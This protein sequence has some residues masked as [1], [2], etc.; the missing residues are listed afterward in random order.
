MFRLAVC[1]LILAAAAICGCGRYFA[2]DIN[3]ERHATEEE[4]EGR[5]MLAPTTLDL[6]RRDGYRPETGY[7][8]EIVFHENGTCDFRSIIPN[9]G[10]VATYHDLRGRWELRHD[11]KT[12]GGK[13]IKNEVSIEA[14]QY[15]LRLGVTEEDKTLCL[16]EFWG[17]P[18]SW[19]FLKYQKTDKR[20]SAPSP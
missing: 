11:A 12:S 16:W 13:T 18:D 14:G 9:I 5:W 17:D 10:G 3:L 7:L 19:E 1:S 2:P 20:H 4:I 8:H 15:S 6:A